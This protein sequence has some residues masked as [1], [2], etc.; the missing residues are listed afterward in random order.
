MKLSTLTVLALAG[1]SMPAMAQSIMNPS[2]EVGP[3][4]TNW[5][6]VNLG[7]TS[8]EGWVVSAGNIDYIGSMWAAADGSR[9]V[10]LNGDV[11]GAISQSFST[12]AGREY[13]VQ[14]ALSGN[15]SGA[16]VKRLL[17][18]A[19]DESAEFSVAIAGFS[20]QNMNWSNQSFSF[21]ADSS[22]TEIT[23]ASLNTNRWGAAV[24]DIRVTL[25]PA[26]AAG[27]ALL[28]G[29]GLRRRRR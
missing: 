17:L 13:V 20:A 15:W 14:F 6:R 29:L 4:T 12:I 18:T 1:L 21:I 8:I 16:A 3:A 26:P 11:P 28:G 24:D 5:S 27:L 25:V 23:F 10:E 9:S 22:A 2:Y 7:E 19:G